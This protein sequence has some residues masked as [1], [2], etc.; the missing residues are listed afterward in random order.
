MKSSEALT[1]MALGISALKVKAG[2]LELW[3]VVD[4]LHVAYG[5]VI[6]YVRL[7]MEQELEEEHGE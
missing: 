5:A 1:E 3:D 7:A 6:V 4:A 2:I